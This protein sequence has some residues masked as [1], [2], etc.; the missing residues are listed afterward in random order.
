MSF[1]SPFWSRGLWISTK[2]LMIYVGW[3]SMELKS[4]CFPCASCSS[5][6]SLSQCVATISHLLENASYQSHTEIKLF[7]S[8]K[9]WAPIF[10][11]GVAKIV[12]HWSR[13]ATSGFSFQS[14]CANSLSWYAIFCI[15]LLHILS[16]LRPLIT[17]SPL[18]FWYFKLALGSILYQF[19]VSFLQVFP[20]YVRLQMYSTTSWEVSLHGWSF[21]FYYESV[22]WITRT[23][24][25]S[26]SALEFRHICS[27][28]NWGKWFLL[29]L[30]LLINIF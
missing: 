2:F 1:G 26:L 5:S 21:I 27:H 11:S 16:V 17:P 22:T 6:N 30:L 19:V 24:Q 7:T 9:L 8:E 10:C 4:N 28:T 3:N 13:K 15:S 29:L 12:T 18:R 14:I 25:G 20:L 23:K